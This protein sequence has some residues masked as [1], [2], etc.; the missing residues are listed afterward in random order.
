VKISQMV[1]TVKSS[2][3]KGS[4]KK[5]YLYLTGSWALKVLLKVT[6]PCIFWIIPLVIP[7]IINEPI[8]P[9]KNY[10][11][12]QLTYWLRKYVFPK[13]LIYT[14]PVDKGMKYDE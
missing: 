4:K 3:R 6:I 1:F 5:I 13:L 14:V 8:K 7:C 12:I 9:F 10:F 11:T 2:T